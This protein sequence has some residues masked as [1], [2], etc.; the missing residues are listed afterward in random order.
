MTQLYRPSFQSKPT[1]PLRKKPIPFALI[2]IA[3]AFIISIL[4]FPVFWK[5]GLSKAKE[6]SEGALGKKIIWILAGFILVSVIYPLVMA[7][8]SKE[9]IGRWWQ[10]LLGRCR[11]NSESL[12]RV[13]GFWFV[14]IVFVFFLF[15][16]P[17]M[18]QEKAES[19]KTTPT[20]GEVTKRGNQKLFG[21]VES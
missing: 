3:I 13:A 20:L 11:N 19:P 8:P 12:K 1:P 6:F 21:V 5:D 16:I 10:R 18:Y 7:K 15:C 2:V 4:C 9:E 17:Q 14:S